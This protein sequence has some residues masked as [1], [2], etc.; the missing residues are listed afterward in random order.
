MRWP[1]R[2]R[3][4]MHSL[5]RR[6]RS[7]R[8]LDGEI[9]FHLQQQIN[10]HIAQGMDPD[11]ARHAALRSLGAVTQVAEEC[12]DVRNVNFLDNLLQDLRFGFRMLRRSPGFSLLAILCLTLGIGA[13][14]AVFSWIEGILL[15]PYPAVVDQDRLLV[16]AGTARG[17]ADLD[18][19]S[20]P[21][22]VDFQRRCRLIDAVIAEKITGVTLS[23]GDRAERA[24][25]SVVSANYFD[26]LGIRPILGRGFVPDEDF[27]RNAHPV[28]V[29]SYQLW[30][31]RFHGDPEIIGKTQVLN[32]LPHTIIGVAPEGFY[33]TFVGYA[34]QFWVPMSMQERFEP[35]GYLLEDRGER[36]IEGFVRLK[37]GVTAA[38][39]EAEM[40]SV[41]QRLEGEYPASNRGR[42]IKLL[43]LWQSPFNGAAATLPT[44]GIGLGVVVFVLL[45]VCANV[46]NLLLVR[47]FAR[48]HEMTVRLAVG[49]GRTR[50]VQQLLTEG[51]ILSLI[52]AAGGLM[53]A[54]WLRN[55]LVLVIPWRGVPVY[56]AGQIDWRVLALSISVCLISTLLF[57][58]V[59]ALET[60]KLD[61]A[62]SL[63]SE[64]AGVVGAGKRSQVRGALVLL[65][66]A[67]S[68]ILLVGAALVIQSLQ[69]IRTGSPGFSTDGI[70]LTSIDLF[71]SGYDAERARNFEDQLIERVR[72]LAGIESAAYARVTPFSYRTYFSS[73]IAVDG[74]QS[75]PDEQPTVEYN[76]VGPAYFTTM[77][78]PLVSGREFTDADNDTSLPVAIVNETMAAHY[79][80]G[81]D[82]LG[83]RI[84]MKG[85]SMQVVGVA[86]LAKYSNILETPK[87]L[88]YVPLRQ[89]FSTQLALNVRTTEDPGS[90][91]TALASEMHKLD[92]ALAPYEV[93]T[94]QQQIERS[95]WP[96]RI[97]L[98]LLGVFSA[99]ALVLAAVGMYGVMSYVVSQNT[100]E[101]G[102]RMALG[103]R[104]SHLLRLVITQGLA[105]TA[106]G[107][108]VG[109][110]AALGL[111]R[112]LGYLLYNVSPRDPLAFGSALA[113]MVVASLAA[114]F[115]P[116]IRATRTNPMSALRG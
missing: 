61:L 88:F 116:A 16:L 2:L 76:Q 98:T 96:Q 89:N 18:E 73:P 36:W 110:A 4:W 27:G 72:A 91:A 68:F 104:A 103:A 93:I 32:G 10:E 3:F 100:C 115:L 13:N 5:F 55:A 52:A 70:L 112:L 7:E 11:E 101:L 99:L 26:A 66:I 56:M 82:P 92:P 30:Q 33:G 97:A 83:K 12:R 21:D 111:T 64:S 46:S 42:G 65:Q 87:P 43:R 90:F 39:A 17:Q 107:M 79:W 95:T 84:Q 78:I 105:L 51:I 94:M 8:E 74:Y 113:V 1:Y 62:T 45:I 81:Q 6:E 48:R 77:G 57:A 47:A 54:H 106:G 63:K 50:L 28:V 35:G 85:R 108:V 23:I 102:L 60:S 109:A 59:P 37:P 67:L 14:T 34:W 41:A 71:G 25:G 80:P 20:W 22:L 31:S 15:K 75:A 58:L 69:R 86:R 49:A 24:A 53:L 40:R 9:E 44:L 29:I 114:C 19:I 38:Q